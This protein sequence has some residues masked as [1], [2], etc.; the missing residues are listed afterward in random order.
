MVTTVLAYMSVYYTDF[1]LFSPEVATLYLI[2]L[3]LHQLS[4]QG[5]GFQ[6][7]LIFMALIYVSYTLSPSQ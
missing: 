2:P 6:N 4:L 5:E 3:L 1:F 7:R